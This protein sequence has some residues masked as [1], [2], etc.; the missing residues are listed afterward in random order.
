MEGDS[1]D[2]RTDLAACEAPRPLPERVVWRLALA[3]ATLHLGVQKRR[4][5][6]P[7]RTGGRVKVVWQWSQLAVP[8]WVRVLT[9]LIGS[10]LLVAD[11][12][13]WSPVGLDMERPRSGSLNEALELC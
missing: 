6:P 1:G 7:R 13:G 8:A 2:S 10:G 11:W 9:A 3:P 12:S 5:L 4:A